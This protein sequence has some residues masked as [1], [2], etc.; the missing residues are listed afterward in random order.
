M[1]F[2]YGFAET[3]MNLSVGQPI[4]HPS[5][6]PTTIDGCLFLPDGSRYQPSAGSAGGERQ[7]VIVTGSLAFERNEQGPLRLVETIR[8][9]EHPDR[10][11]FLDWRD[12]E[13]AIVPQIEHAGKIYVPPS[14]NGGLSS[15]LTL[16]S[17]ISP[18][19]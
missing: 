6:S 16:P 9:P 11:V 17:G 18:C 15:H 13:Y 12:G 14:A 1:H 19:G 4:V 7:R 3:R 2:N 5:S 10:L 8:E